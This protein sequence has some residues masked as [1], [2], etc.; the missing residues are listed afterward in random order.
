MEKIT[1]V[2][3][4]RKEQPSKFK[5]GETYNI[6]TVLDEKGRKLVAMGGWADAWKIGDVIEVEINEKTWKD[7]EGFDQVSLNLTNPN[8]KPWTGGQGGAVVN[9]T[10]IS[11]QIAAQLSSILFADSKKKIKLDDI[12]ALADEIKKRISVAAPAEKIKEIDVDKQ[13][14]PAKAA[15]KAEPA[16]DE[17][18]IDDEKPF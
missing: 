10:I 2:K 14:A 9:T 18:E 11:Y 13:D 7:K 5:P 12:S 16:I 1:I 8:K 3:I 6:T 15:S 17:E 4:G